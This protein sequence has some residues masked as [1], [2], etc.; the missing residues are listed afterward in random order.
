MRT[1]HYS[2]RFAIVL[3]LTLAF[4]LA[5]AFLLHQAVQLSALV[6]LLCAAV[7][8]E[9]LWVFLEWIGPVIG[10]MNK[11]KQEQEHN[12]TVE[13]LLDCSLRY[14]S[15]LVI[16][17]IRSKKR[18]SL[19]VV[20]RLFRKPDIVLRHAPGYLLILMPFTTL[21]QASVP[22]KR[23]I[24]LLPVKHIVQADVSMLQLLVEM[25]RVHSHSEE[26][27]A[28]S[29]DLR[30]MCFQAFDAKF[31][32]I[33]PGNEQSGGPA[34]YNLYEPGTPDALSDWLGT[35]QQVEPDTDTLPGAENKNTMVGEGSLSTLK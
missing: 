29:H 27:I 14:A 8:T 18:L 4:Y 11:K 1:I 3:A 26:T 30:S 23:L 7:G 10:T 34:I 6:A 13:Y 16:A 35:L 9:R 15:P 20:A 31:A 17:A 5:I 25:Q 22:L 32:N 24:T 33:K 28:T 19:H 21:E 12:Q 2:I